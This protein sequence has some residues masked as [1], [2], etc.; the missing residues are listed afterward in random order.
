VLNN[1][2]KLID[3]KGLDSVIV[4]DKGKKTVKTV[5]DKNGIKHKVTVYEAT[6]YKNTTLKDYR[7]GNLSGKQTVQV[8]VGIT[9]E[10]EKAWEAKAKDA[11]KG[12][13]HGENMDTPPGTFIVGPPSGP[14][15]TANGWFSFRTPFDAVGQVDHEGFKHTGMEIHNGSP[16]D[17]QGCLT[18]STPD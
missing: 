18:M 17:S 16:I 1:P 6:I 11:G 12:D 5:T 14:H 13:P 7:A 2:M 9:A 3:P 4:I 10:K 8:Q 15:G